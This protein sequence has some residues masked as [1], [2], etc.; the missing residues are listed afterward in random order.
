MCLYVFVYMYTCTY[1]GR[2]CTKLLWHTLENFFEW[3]KF[4]VTERLDDCAGDARSIRRQHLR[5]IDIMINA[6]L[7]AKCNDARNDVLSS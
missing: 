3:K 4:A 2:C 7:S 5:E 1:S 6:Q